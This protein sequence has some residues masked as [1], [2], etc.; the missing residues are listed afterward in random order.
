MKR[1]LMGR[2]RRRSG[3]RSRSWPKC[4]AILLLEGSYALVSSAR[5]DCH[6]NIVVLPFFSF[7]VPVFVIACKAFFAEN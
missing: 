2:K 1:S 4:A 7:V 6:R 5:F 3:R